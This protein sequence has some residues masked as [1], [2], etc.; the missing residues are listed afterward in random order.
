ML[1]SNTLDA[2]FKAVALSA[3]QRPKSGLYSPRG[4]RGAG[5]AKRNAGWYLRVSPNLQLPTGFILELPLQLPRRLGLRQMSGL[6][7]PHY[8]P[9]SISQFGLTAIKGVELLCA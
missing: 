5:T 8:Q 3:C 9:L 4:I 2:G 7:A 6:M 1:G